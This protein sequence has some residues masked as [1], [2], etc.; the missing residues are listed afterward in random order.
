M[1]Y[2]LTLFDRTVI[3]TIRQE[4]F[5][6]TL[7][8]RQLALEELIISLGIQGQGRKLHTGKVQ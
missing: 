6:G 3:K 2:F 5:L 1:R 7:E 4:I 8:T